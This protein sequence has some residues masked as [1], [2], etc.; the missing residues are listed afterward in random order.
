MGF[1]HHLLQS[2]TRY[3]KRSN[4]CNLSTRDMGGHPQWGYLPGT[5]WHHPRWY[6]VADQVIPELVI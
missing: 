6:V 3:I 5:D 1:P 2:L 4:G